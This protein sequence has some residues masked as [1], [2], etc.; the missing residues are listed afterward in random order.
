MLRRSLL[1]LCLAF[2]VTACAS[3]TP[4][5]VETSP[6][7]SETPCWNSPLTGLCADETVPVLAVKIDDVSAARPQW[8]LNEADVVVVEPVEG[9]LTRLF[10][11]YQSEIPTTLGPIRSA[12]ITDVDIAAAFGEPGFAYSGASRRTT[13][14]LWKSSMQ[15]V[16]APQGGLGYSRASD[17]YAPHNLMGN[18]EE[19][20]SRIKKP[21]KALLGNRIAWSFLDD[22]TS[23]IEGRDIISATA[24]WP[25]SDKTFTWDA[26]L[27]RWLVSADG[28][29][30]ESISDQGVQLAQTT[31]VFVM[32][33][34]TLETWYLSSGGATPYLKTFGEGNGWVLMNGQ[35]IKAVWKRPT[36]QDF[37]RWYT[38][39]GVEIAVPQG[40]AW[41]LLLSER[42]EMKFKW[43]KSPSPTPSS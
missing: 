22:S 18:Y 21:A 6:T 12:R 35:A 38:T 32:N 9:G 10:A 23:A 27:K 41:W 20:I 5:Q 1:M 11:V 29:D 40:N 7:Q 30:T 28:K 2:V 43:V 16:G 24:D 13:P 25:A 37:P 39:E 33:A 31:N 8:A 17:R 4:S 26:S 19:I 3:Q 36:I 42:D 15:L 34:V 14:Y